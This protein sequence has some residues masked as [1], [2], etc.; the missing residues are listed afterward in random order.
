MLSDAGRNQWSGPDLHFI[1]DG[2]RLRYS[3]RGIRHHFSYAV[4]SIECITRNCFHLVG[5]SVL[6]L[7]IPQL[8][9]ES[10]D[11]R[12]GR[13]F[14]HYLYFVLPFS[15]IHPETDTRRYGY[16]YRVYGLF[17]YLRGISLRHRPNRQ[18]GSGYLHICNCYK[19]L[20][21]QP[22]RFRRT[23]SIERDDFI[24]LKNYD[25]ASAVTVILIQ[26]SRGGSSWSPSPR[27]NL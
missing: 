2:V 5:K 11:L 23:G 16:S 25:S 27:G 15:K 8:S 4:W 14:G 9:T 1:L 10:R 13:R 24:R 26:K 19:N 7:C 22:R 12:L 6:G 20:S 3:T 18:S 17:L 21:H